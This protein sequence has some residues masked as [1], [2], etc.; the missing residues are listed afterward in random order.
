MKTETHETELF[1]EGAKIVM[2]GLLQL[3]PMSRASRLEVA[4]LLLHQSGDRQRARRAQALARH[5]AHTETRF[6]LFIHSFKK[7]T[8]YHE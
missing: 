5:L 7:G 6:C 2:E 1:R 3:D 8:K 4:A